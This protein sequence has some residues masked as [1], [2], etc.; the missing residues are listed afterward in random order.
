MNGALASHY[1][2]ALAD[3]VLTPGSNLSGEEAIRQFRTA[4]EVIVGSKDLERALLSP[5]VPKRQREALIGKL[6][7]E[8]GLH[9]LVKNFM[10][11]LVAHRRVSEVAGIGREFEKVM[12]ERLGWIPA[13]ITSARELDSAHKEH[14]ERSLGTALGKY[15]RPHYKVDPDM[16]AGVRARVASREYDATLR[17]KLESMRQKLTATT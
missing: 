3:A 11:V 7:D 15:I 17:G 4:Q 16:L 5:A 8:L 14:I 13:E 1:A 10:L 9:R 12:D 6:A 2:R